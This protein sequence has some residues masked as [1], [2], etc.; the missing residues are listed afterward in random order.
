MPNI[1]R[2]CSRAYARSRKSI[3]DKVPVI[4]N[5]VAPVQ[6]GSGV[7]SPSKKVS[8]KRSGFLPGDSLFEGVEFYNQW[9]FVFTVPAPV[10]KNPSPASPQQ[11]RVPGGKS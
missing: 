3:G 6:S 5:T 7:A 2:E 4:T 8:L 9:K 11:T 1:S 10:G